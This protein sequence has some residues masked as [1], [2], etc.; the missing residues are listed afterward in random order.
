MTQIILIGICAGLTAALPLALLASAAAD[1]LFP[2]MFVSL[3]VLFFYLSPLPIFIAC[4]GWSVWSGLAAAVVAGLCFAAVFGGFF[5]LAFFF[6]LALPACWLG[7]LALLA[8]PAEDQPRDRLEWYP[9]GRIVLW[10]AL[11][12]GVVV[13]ATILQFGSD[14]EAIRASLR[15]EVVAAGISGGVLNPDVLAAIVPPAAAGVITI[16]QLLNLWLAARILRAFG[17]LNRPWPELP[18][19]TFPPVAAALLAVAIAG[20]FLSGL[21]AILFSTLLGSL[22]TAYAI[23]GLAVLHVVTRGID[24]RAILLTAVYAVILLFVWAA[25]ILSALGFAETALNLRGRAVG[26]RGP[27]A[28]PKTL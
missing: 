11:I 1:S 3:S 15:N 9:V 24:T 18:A 16:I 27:P 5:P 26:K 6:G 20:T 7:Y 19:I 14:A 8:R 12:G 23:L 28:P 21:P 17:R 4:L 22:L 13:A 10:A 25:L 2:V